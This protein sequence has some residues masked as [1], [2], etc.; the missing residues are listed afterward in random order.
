MMRRRVVFPEPDGPSSAS[1]LPPGTS[2]LTL[3]SARKRSNRLV[4][5]VIRMLI[6]RRRYH[7]AG[8]SRQQVAVV[9]EVEAVP[10][11]PVTANAR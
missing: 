6:R 3:S 9:R 11:E 5:P 4:T 8:G 1:R 7:A 10:I 2:R